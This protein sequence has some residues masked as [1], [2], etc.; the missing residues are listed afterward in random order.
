MH[1]IDHQWFGISLNKMFNQHEKYQH[2][3]HLLDKPCLLRNQ[4][5]FGIRF[6]SM[7][8]ALTAW[9]FSMGFMGF[10][11]RNSWALTHVESIGFPLVFH[12]FSVCVCHSSFNPKNNRTFQNNVFFLNKRM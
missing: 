1:E 8:N 12:W 5:L 10:S 2:E 11:T 7:R 9:F 3:K 6:I 4:C